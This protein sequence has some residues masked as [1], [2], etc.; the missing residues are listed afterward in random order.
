IRRSVAGDLRVYTRAARAR[1]LL[2]LEDQ[3]RAA[4]REYEA[5]ALRV[6]RTRR[7][8]GV[9]VLGERRHLREGGDGQGMCGSFGSADDA[10]VEIAISDQA[11]ALADRVVRRGARRQG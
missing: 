4:F 8:L 5:A 10:E 9:G 11:H 2:G 6:E 1:V 7:C 3:G